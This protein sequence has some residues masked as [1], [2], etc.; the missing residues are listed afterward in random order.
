[1]IFGPGPERAQYQADLKMHTAFMPTQ[2]LT[3]VE[4][5]IGL[6]GTSRLGMVDS[7]N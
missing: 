3:L 5:D 7:R 2:T 4:K 6:S 1:M